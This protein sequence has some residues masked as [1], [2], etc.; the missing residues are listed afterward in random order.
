MCLGLIFGA[1]MLPENKREKLICTVEKVPAD[2]SKFKKFVEKAA[3]DF[4]ELCEWFSPSRGFDKNLYFAKTGND[5]LIDTVKNRYGDLIREIC[6]EKNIPADTNLVVA[7]IIK[8]SSGN[9]NARIDS[10]NDG[11][12]LMGVTLAT[13]A[14]YGVSADKLTNPYWNLVAGISY[15]A[16]LL[17]IY[18]GDT[19]KSLVA[20]NKGPGALDT[21]SHPEKTRYYQ[22]AM[23]LKNAAAPAN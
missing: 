11:S 20:Y 10:P 14:K 18:H 9:P 23:A 21:T 2:F 15:L 17:Q 19:A 1:I 3:S 8:E 5:G 12:G 4:D 7:I 16:H 6:R 22:E 13:A